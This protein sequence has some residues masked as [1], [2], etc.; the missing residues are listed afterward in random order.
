[1]CCIE[2]IRWIDVFGQGAAQDACGNWAFVR[3]KVA[4]VEFVS[5]EVV[6]NV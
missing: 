3:L 5:G 2:S 4:S 1:M 6:S